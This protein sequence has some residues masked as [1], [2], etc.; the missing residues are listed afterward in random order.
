LSLS[1][2]ELTHHARAAETSFVGV[3]CGVMDQMV[4]VMATAGHA[5]F[6]DTRSGHAEQIPLEPAACGLALL[7]F[8]THTRHLHAGGEYA[9]RRR[10]CAEAAR[11]IGV[12]A[13]RDVSADDLDRSLD[14][15]GDS[16][17]GRVVRHVVTENARTL[18]AAELLR[19]GRMAEMG[20]LL[21]Q[22]HGSLRDDFAVSSPELDSVVDA[23]RG[24][25]ALG[26][27]MTGGGFG[28]CAIALV[29]E[30]VASEVAGA[31]VAQALRRGWRQPTLVDAT[32]S[33]GL[34]REA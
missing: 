28:G 20:P 8:D 7:V 32:P 5:L 34:R 25:G 2:V 14:S 1:P 16:E 33:G 18:L 11:R 30:G 3:P 22:S 10:A 19:E 12:P 31:V 6:V 29:P 21:T 9:D 23:A 27:R 24:A 4:S 15:L 13:L 26:A 17:L